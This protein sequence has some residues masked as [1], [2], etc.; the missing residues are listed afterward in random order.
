MLAFPNPRFFDFSELA[1]AMRWIPLSLVCASLSESRPLQLWLLGFVMGLRNPPVSAESLRFE[2]SECL[3]VRCV[4]VSG[5]SNITRCIP[6]MFIN[7]RIL[8]LVFVISER[9]VS[10]CCQHSGHQYTSGH[11]HITHFPPQTQPVSPCW[12][13]IVS[14]GSSSY[15]CTT[16]VLNRKVSLCPSEL[17]LIFIWESALPPH[18]IVMK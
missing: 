18:P 2:K 1:H 12:T 3:A 6:G 8:I 17:F 7:R 14:P 15:L 16:E 10:S 13:R 4:W 11:H 5:G 9:H